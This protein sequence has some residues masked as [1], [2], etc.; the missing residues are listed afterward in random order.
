MNLSSGSACVLGG[1]MFL[2]SSGGLPLGRMLTSLGHPWADVLDFL[3]D[4]KRKFDPNVK[5]FEAV[6]RYF[7]N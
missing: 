3:K 7:V 5:D 4:S 2:G 1:D 6:F